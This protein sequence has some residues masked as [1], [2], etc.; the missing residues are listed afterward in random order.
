MEYFLRNGIKIEIA[1]VC[2][3]NVVNRITRSYY[4]SISKERY[5]RLLNLELQN[6]QELQIRQLDN[7]FGRM[8]AIEEFWKELQLIEN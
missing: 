8:L 5:E 1:T 3:D 7:D 6:A 4:P 2:V